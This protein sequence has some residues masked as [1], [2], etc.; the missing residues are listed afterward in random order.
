MTKKKVYISDVTL[1]DGQH[2]RRHQYTL[3]Q[4]TAIAKALD[5]A[6][7]DSIEISHGDG[8]A[9]SSF[10]YGFGLHTDVEW[11]E[12]V[13]AMVKHAQV[14][15]LLIP[16]IGTLH[17]LDAAYKAGARTVDLTSRPSRESANRLYQRLGFSL[18]T[19]NVYRY[20]LD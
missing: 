8:L 17:D 1:R 5:E 14:A 19:S 3:T 10:N 20:D 11:I 13:A 7:V 15:T 6:K 18:R 2:P 16:G 4:V 12:A 9:G